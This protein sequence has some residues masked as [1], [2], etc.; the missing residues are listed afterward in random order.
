MV[1]QS[2][3]SETVVVICLQSDP[4]LFEAMA[5][6]GAK[7]TIK[8]HDAKMHEAEEAAEKKRLQSGLVSVGKI[9]APGSD[10]EEMYKLYMASPKF[11]EQRD[12]ILN[13][14]KADKSCKWVTTITRD[15]V[16]E[17]QAKKSGAEG[18]CTKC[19]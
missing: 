14:F 8:K 10:K 6:K 19:S 13:M 2:G 5:P 16:F 7:A 12:K 11:S 3:C 9:A 4:A 18:V 15:K 1:G 17:T